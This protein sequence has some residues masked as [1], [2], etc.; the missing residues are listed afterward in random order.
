MANKKY[1]NIVVQLEFSKKKKI[2]IIKK[3]QKLLNLIFYIWCHEIVVENW[4]IQN[5]FA[6]N[7]YLF[8]EIS[9]KEI[10]INKQ[11]RIKA[12]TWAE[13]DTRKI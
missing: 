7:Y 6:M 10:W 2:I 13:M 12:A 8:L 4:S 9:A 11:I 1:E 5:I 3:T